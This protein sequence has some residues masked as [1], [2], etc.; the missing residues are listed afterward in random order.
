MFSSEVE[1]PV[2]GRGWAGSVVGTPRRGMVDRRTATL[3]YAGRDRR[4]ATRRKVP[5]TKRAPAWPAHSAH[6]DRSCSGGA[7]ARGAAGGHRGAD[8]SGD[9]WSVTMSGGHLRPQESGQLPGDGGDDHVGGVLAGGQ[10]PE[11]AAQPQL[12]GPGAG[13]YLGVQA[14][15]ALAKLEPDGGAVLVGPGRPRPAGRAGGRCRSW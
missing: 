13:G 3:M 2:P 10:P 11:A 9:Q 4:S 5:L 1:E 14:L 7:P 15:L 8:P 6:G 12:G